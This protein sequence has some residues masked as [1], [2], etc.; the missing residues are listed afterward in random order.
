MTNERYKNL[1]PLHTAN[2]ILALAK[3][4]KIPITPMQ[5]IKLTYF[6]YGWCLV[7]LNTKIFQEK[8]KAWRFGPVIPSLYH[9]FK[10]FGSNSITEYGMDIDYTTEDKVDDVKLPRLT[11]EHIEI[12]KVV[13]TV[14]EQYKN[15]SASQLSAI[16]HQKDSPWSKAYAK[17]FNTPLNDTDIKER[18][19]EF[20]NN[21]ENMHN[22]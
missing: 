2:F 22:E 8:I 6:C 21:L 7:K 15:H 3:E 11:K 13:N 19:A 10:R 17:G 18:C 16:T 14:F 12:A 5:L 20:I 4:K 9:E 1:T